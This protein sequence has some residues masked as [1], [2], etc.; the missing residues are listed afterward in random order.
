[1]NKEYTYYFALGEV[2]DEID[3]YWDD[4]ENWGTA[5]AYSAEWIF[6]LFSNKT[7]TYKNFNV[8]IDKCKKNIVDGKSKVYEYP[9]DI[10]SYTKD[11]LE[12]LD[13]DYD[14][15]IQ[16]MEELYDVS[17]GRSFAPLIWGRD[18]WEY[19]DNYS[20]D[21]PPTLWRMRI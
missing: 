5:L 12:Y 17:F 13:I 10:N 4:E 19:D 3:S 8:M 2:N 6:M 15:I 11:D 14:D 18:V 1:M 21:N 9:D 16:E 7:I 20:E